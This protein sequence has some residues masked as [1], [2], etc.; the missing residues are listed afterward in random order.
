MLPDLSHSTG[1]QVA[2]EA[3][4]NMNIVVTKL[5]KEYGILKS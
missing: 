2:C 3:E 4:F 1:S 5:I